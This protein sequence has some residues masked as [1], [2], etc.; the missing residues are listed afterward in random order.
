MVSSIQEEVCCYR[1]NSRIQSWEE[2]DHPSAVHKRY[3]PHCLMVINKV[4]FEHST[5]LVHN[6]KVRNTAPHSSIP[7]QA[8][9]RLKHYIRCPISTQ[10]DWL[11]DTESSEIWKSLSKEFKDPYI[12]II[13]QACETRTG[14]EDDSIPLVYLSHTPFQW[15]VKTEQIQVWMKDNS[16]E[17][18]KSVAKLS[19]QWKD[20]SKEKKYPFVCLSSL[21]NS[22]NKTKLIEDIINYY[23]MDIGLA[24][25]SKDNV[26]IR[27]KG[28]NEP[29]T[30]ISTLLSQRMSSLIYDTYKTTDIHNV[31]KP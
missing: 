5:L 18:S 6:L 17:K 7:F 8:I 23:N 15:F 28:I 14:H 26:I 1:C 4:R 31:D 3:A 13:Q 24:A 12:L 19:A 11:I 9:A 27:V 16:L 22:R 29:L 10:P 20:L 21:D 30:S 25:G 2:K